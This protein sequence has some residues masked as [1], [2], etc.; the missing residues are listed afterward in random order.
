MKVGSDEHE[1][2]DAPNKENYILGVQQQL[3]HNTASTTEQH[4][5]NGHLD[6]YGHWYL[7]IGHEMILS[8]CSYTSQSTLIRHILSNCVNRQNFV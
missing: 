7:I 8:V 3:E 1:V 5:V 4:H 6:A 2:F